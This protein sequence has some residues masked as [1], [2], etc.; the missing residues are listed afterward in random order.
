M[1]TN[2]K[3]NL[4]DRSKFTYQEDG[5][6]AVPTSYIKGIDCRT[7]RMNRFNKFFILY[8]RAIK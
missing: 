1:L 7:G 8:K 6:I 2:T 5:Y 3:C 4:D